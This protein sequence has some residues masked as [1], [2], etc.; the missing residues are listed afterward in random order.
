MI[1]RTGLMVPKALE[2]WVTATIRVRGLSSFSYSSMR[3]SP[4]SFMRMTRSLAPFSSHNICQGTILEWCSIAEMT[5][6]SPAFTFLR[7]QELLTRFMPS[8]VPRTKIS[9][10]SEHL[11][12][13]DIGVVLHRRNDDLVAR[14]HVL[15][16][17]GTADQ[18]YA[19]GGA[20]DKDQFLFA[21]RV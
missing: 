3:S 13:D 4:R 2:T 12:G 11:P 5:I 15:A 17:P 19:F 20:A 10:R 16:S 18:I 7:P 21:A 1:S 14:L 6:S 8:V 9:S